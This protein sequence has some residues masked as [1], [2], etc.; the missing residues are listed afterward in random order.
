MK[1]FVAAHCKVHEI[2]HAQIT[3]K[4]YEKET[5][6]DGKEEYVKT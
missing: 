5:E 1:D 3:I 2:R 4:K 6:I